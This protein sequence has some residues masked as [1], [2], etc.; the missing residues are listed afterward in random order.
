[1]IEMKKALPKGVRNFRT[2]V[3]DK[4]YFVD[5]TLM[6]QEFLQSQTDV[7]LITRPRR[8]GKTLNLSML[9]EFFDITRDS[10]EIFKDTDI[11]KRPCYSEINQYPVIC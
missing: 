10:S 8:F 4:F 9:A 6:I 5:K 2:L 1:M 3:T 7:T 11:A